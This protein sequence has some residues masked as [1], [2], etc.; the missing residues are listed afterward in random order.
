AILNECARVGVRGIIDFGMGLTLREGDRE[1]YYAALDKHFP[2]LK[3]KYIREFGN[4]YEIP[5]PNAKNLYRIFNDICRKNGMMS[6]PDECFGFMREFPEKYK[7]MSL[8]DLE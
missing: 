4:A 6:T 3:E 2:G 7:Q 8:F 1:Y 5:S